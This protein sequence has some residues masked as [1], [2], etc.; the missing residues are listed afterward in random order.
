MIAKPTYDKLK[1]HLL[2][3][4]VPGAAV[5]YSIRKVNGNYNG[6]AIRV[7]RSSDDAELDIGFAYNY[8]D[9]GQ[10]K[11]FVGLDTAYVTKWY[12]QSGNER[13]AVQETEGNQPIIVEA[14]V[15]VQQGKRIALKFNG[16]SD[17][18][19]IANFQ[20]ANY[21]SFTILALIN[22]TRTA[23]VN[24]LFGK[25]FTSTNNRGFTFSV[26]DGQWSSNIVDNGSVNVTRVDSTSN[27]PSGNNLCI[28]VFDGGEINIIDRINFIRNSN[29]SVKTSVS[30]IDN[31]QSF[32]ATANFEIGSVNHGT[33][34][35]YQGMMQEVIFYESSKEAVRA[36]LE[37]N[38]NNYFGIW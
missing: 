1:H 35:F 20:T 2:I 22:A 25:Y 19:Q 4:E 33:A 28:N 38:V 9:I 3:N 5:A 18:F 13:D 32:N 21:T 36:I 23:G 37:T 14:G 15:M 7:R 24:M 6:N 26:R 29:V 31:Q 10:L 17:N 8:L 12:D 11:A 34:D 16:T 30:L 27:S